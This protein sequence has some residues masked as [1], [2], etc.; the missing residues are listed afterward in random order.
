MNPF[1][2]IEWTWGEAILS[3][4]ARDILTITGIALTLVGF[5]I[6]LVQLRKTQSAAKAA[7]VAAKKTLEESRFAFQKFA[8]AKLNQLLGPFAE[9]ATAFPTS[10]FQ[11]FRGKKRDFWSL[12]PQFCVF[13]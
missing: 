4:S 8:V 12:M 13:G 7:E 5:A 6:T 9:G 3:E 1:V 10:V 11:G 2:A